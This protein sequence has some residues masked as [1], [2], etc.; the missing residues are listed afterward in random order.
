MIPKSSLIQFI[1]LNTS[2]SLKNHPKL[3]HSSEGT[4]S[5]L[6][7][8]FDFLNESKLN[9]GNCSHM[10]G[11]KGTQSCLTLNNHL[12]IKGKSSWD[13]D[14]ADHFWYDN[15][16]FNVNHYTQKQNV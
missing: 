2:K 8:I 9:W 10:N 3:Y 7:Q 6:F 15:P 5:W 1:H 12:R 16:K 4:G 11:K 14:L 13:D